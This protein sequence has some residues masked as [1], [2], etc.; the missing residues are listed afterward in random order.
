MY[1]PHMRE[2]RSLHTLALKAKL[3][4]FLCTQILFCYCVHS[5]RVKC[6]LWWH[7]DGIRVPRHWRTVIRIRYERRTFSYARIFLLDPSHFRISPPI[8]PIPL[9]SEIWPQPQM[10]F[11]ATKFSRYEF[12]V[13][14]FVSMTFLR[15]LNGLYISKIKHCI[16]VQQCKVY[17][18]CV[19]A[20][21]IL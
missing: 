20:R 21:D 15:N 6:W 5:P 7:G 13:E 8:L 17:P 11:T 12:A 2:M 4:C 3:H 10:T 14:F 1:S 18:S 9:P 19:H 16:S